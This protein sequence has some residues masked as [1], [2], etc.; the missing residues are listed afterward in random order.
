MSRV[1]QKELVDFCK[2]DEETTCSGSGGRRFHVPFSCIISGKS[3]CSK[4]ELLLKILLQWKCITTD[5]S[6]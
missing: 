1:Q 6:G 2:S 5:H 4:T 3:Q